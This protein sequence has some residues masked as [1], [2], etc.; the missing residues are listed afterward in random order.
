[1]TR[2]ACG[3]GAPLSGGKSSRTV[4]AGAGTAAMLVHAALL[5]GFSLNAPARHETSPARDQGIAIDLALPAPP[6][7]APVPESVPVPPVTEPEPEKIKPVDPLPPEPAPAPRKTVAVKKPPAHPRRI[8]TRPA[9][10]SRATSHSPQRDS[11]SP[12]NTATDPQPYSAERNPKPVYPEL[13]RKRGQEGDV[14]IRVRVD[15]SGSPVSVSV[16][17]SSGYPLLDKAAEN[18]VRKWRFTPARLNGMAVA[19]DVVVPVRFL[20]R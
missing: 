19:G 17:K 18:G 14:L 2:A 5:F 15:A 12:R 11:A 9:V 6:A 16:E 8:Q 1:M 4:W 13:A 3:E 7:P 10:E 20:L